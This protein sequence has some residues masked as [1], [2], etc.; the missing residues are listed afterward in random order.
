MTRNMMMIAAAAASVWAALAV[1]QDAPVAIDSRREIFV[2]NALIG[3]MNGASLRLQTP[4][5]AGVALA[6][7]NPWEGRYC[8]YVTVFKDGD[9]CRMYYRGLPTSGKDGSAAEVTCYAES[10]DGINWEKPELG[11]FEINGDDDTNVVLAN[12]APFS[13]N[14]SPFKDARPDVPA[15]ARYK[16]VAG[17][18][19]AGLFA[20]ASADGLRWRKLFETPII[21]KGAFDSQNLA[22]W[23]ESEN[24]YVCYLR[25]W[26]EGDFGGVR[27]VSR[28]TSPDFQTWTEPVEMDFAGTPRENLYTN[29]TL[30]YFRAPHLYIALAARF[31]PGR[32]VASVED[33]AKFGV[34]AGYS[35]DC[36][37]VVLITSRGGNKYDRTFMEGFL[38]PGIGFEDWTSRTNY[39]AWGI[40]PT[41][42]EEISFYIQKGYGQPTQHL[43]RYTL[44]PDGFAAVSA[45]YAGGE[46]IT[47][48]LTFTGVGLFINYATSAA[49]DIRVEIQDPAGAP[50]PGYT[51]D[52]ADTIIGNLLDRPVTWKGAADLSTLAGKPVRLRFVMKDADLFALQ[53]R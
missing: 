22:F 37:D 50:I 9:V 41:G 52:D 20:F 30:P 40:I 32:R 14:F 51:L 28:C 35:G 47:K 4:Q 2:D 21:T 1:A 15:D 3:T 31:M 8:G 18:S 17:T 45:P 43:A 26:T 33:A 49:G 25:S 34:E 24:C 13:H 53:F 38:R 46:M 5:P 36:S 10:R 6:F 27:S 48:P 29:Q 12:L 11:L 44:R 42:E 7:D 23:S 16:A 39:S 19:E